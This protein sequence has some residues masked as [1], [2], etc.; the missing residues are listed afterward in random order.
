VKNESKVFEQKKYVYV[1]KAVSKEICDLATQYGLFDSISDFNPD[2]NQVVGAHSKYADPLMESILLLL[3]P[4]VE[5]ATGLKLFPTYSFYRTYKPGDELKPHVD[6]PSCEISLSLC[7]GWSY[8]H[9]DPD[10]K[11]ELIVGDSS[12]GMNQGDIAIYRGLE[13]NHSRKPFEGKEGSFQVQAFCHYVNADGP[14]AFLK[15][16]GRRGIGFPANS[17]DREINLFQLAEEII[18][19]KEK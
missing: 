12:F 9:D 17:R 3:W 1:E 14:F 19:S 7:L 6:R 4:T 16:D 11:W 13:V 15:Q 2:Q 18:E 5:K 8:I 10:Y